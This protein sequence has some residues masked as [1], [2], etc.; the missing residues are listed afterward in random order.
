MVGDK[1]MGTM[2]CQVFKWGLLLGQG[3]HLG[4]STSGWQIFCYQMC[5]YCYGHIGGHCYV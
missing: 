4:L 2:R 5:I 1:V 3:A